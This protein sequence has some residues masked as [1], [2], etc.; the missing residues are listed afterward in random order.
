MTTRHEPAVHASA[1]DPMGATRRDLAENAAAFDHIIATVPGALRLDAATGRGYADGP[2]LVDILSKLMPPARARQLAGSLS[3]YASSGCAVF[4]DGEVLL[5]WRALEEGAA[6]TGGTPRVV[7]EALGIG[8]DD[9]PERALRCIRA[10]RRPAPHGVFSGPRSVLLTRRPD[11]LAGRRLDDEGP[12]F[13]HGGDDD[14][15]PIER[16]GV[17]TPAPP[18]SV[19]DIDSLL[20]CFVGGTW[21]PYYTDPIF[22]SGWIFGCRVCLGYQCA[23]AIATYL[24]RFFAPGPISLAKALIDGVAAGTVAA[25]VASLMGVAAFW[26]G[27]AAFATGFQM[28]HANLLS[29]GRG[30]CMHFP[31]PLNPLP[32]WSESR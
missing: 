1:L 7:R 19:D 30:V 15:P 16:G 27:V 31:W 2:A 9:T 8:R 17:P 26:I 4:D 25:G 20:R 23:D 24:L 13:P 10:G 28:Q 6:L 12:P 14:A 3:G 22:D 5:P 18:P 21:G 29:E 32:V 11:S